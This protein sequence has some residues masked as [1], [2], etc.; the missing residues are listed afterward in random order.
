MNNDLICSFGNQYQSF[1]DWFYYHVYIIAGERVL[2]FH[3]PLIYE[4]KVLKYRT[5]E[6]DNNC[7]E[8]W[9]HYAG[10]NKKWDKFFNYNGHSHLMY[11]TEILSPWTVE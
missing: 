7:T 10:W 4:A 11:Y 2:C 6:D 3:G 1:M 8:Y 5:S 9:V